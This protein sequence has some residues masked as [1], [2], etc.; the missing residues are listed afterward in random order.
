MCLFMITLLAVTSQPAGEPD[1][2]PV[3]PGLFWEYSVGG[4]QSFGADTSDISGE[5]VRN[6]AGV[7]QHEDG[8]PVS[9]IVT[10][11]TITFTPRSG[12]A[13]S[14]S[15]I[16]DTFYVCS[17]DSLVLRYQSLDSHEAFVMMR[18]PL[19]VG[20]TWSFSPS[21]PTVDRVESLDETVTVPAGLFTGCAYVHEPF[22]TPGAEGSYD[23]F[24][25]A[26][27]T[28]LVKFVLHMEVEDRTDNAIFEL[29][30]TR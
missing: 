8:F 19:E 11:A 27:G 20:L 2:Y 28:G 15:A 13:A 30:E 25:F 24:Y 1:W 18:L 9:M 16:Q 5:M 26:D 10:S 22:T 3:A 21:V 23:D 17:T 12:E 6:V 14:T 7:F 4:T 29:V